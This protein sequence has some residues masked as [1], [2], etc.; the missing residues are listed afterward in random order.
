MDFTIVRIGDLTSNGNRV[1]KM[2]HKVETETV[3]GTMRQSETYYVA[4]KDNSVKVAVGQVIDLDPSEFQMIE[5]PFVHPETG[6]EIML[7]WLSL[8]R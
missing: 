1:V 2:Q 3:L 6:E 7:K 4:V 5:R 8:K